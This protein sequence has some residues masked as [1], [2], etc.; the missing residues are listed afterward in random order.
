MTFNSPDGRP[1]WN[2][3]TAVTVQKPQTQQL[4]DDNSKKRNAVD[5]YEPNPRGARPAWVSL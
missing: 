1:K 2:T 4:N 5:E 3:I